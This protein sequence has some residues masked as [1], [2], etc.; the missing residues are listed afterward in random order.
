[1]LQDRTTDPVLAIALSVAAHTLLFA[2]LFVGLRGARPLPPVHIPGP[3]IE[4]VF[5]D[6]TATEDA[7]ARQAELEQEAARR[8][9]EEQ[10]RAEQ[11]R[12]Q[13]Q[14]RREQERLR[15]VEL[16]RQAQLAEQRRLEEQQRRELEEIRRQREEAERQR[17]LE[18][19]RLAQI[20][21]QRR[22]E[23]AERQQREQAAREQREAA[24]RLARERR[25]G[26]A[27]RQRAGQEGEIAS[28]RAQ[29]IAAIRAVVEANWLRP[30]TARAG[31]Q[32]RV[33]VTQI[34]GGE[35]IAV[36]VIPN[37]C[38]ADEPTQRSVEQ[39][40]MRAQ[41]LPFRGFESVFERQIEFN[42]APED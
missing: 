22:R 23:E 4:A 9:A 1:M 16:E 11:Q 25:E 12:Q 37:R 19:E 36:N 5:I 3:A 30:P 24:E 27:E 17:R 2:L 31:L 28:L 15:E 20:E 21:A 41:P 34:P 35:V 18:A 6:I 32:C 38:N 14:Q 7:R 26:E 42:F 10:R 40:V 29:Y 13:E 33:R 39:A 8:R